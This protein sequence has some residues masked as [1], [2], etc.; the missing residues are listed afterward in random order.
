MAEP[1]GDNAALDSRLRDAFNQAAEQ[2]DS[3]GVADAIRSRIAAGDSGASVAASTAPGWGGGGAL[4]WLPWLG[5]IV[6]A[7]LGG[8]ALGASG[9]VGTEQQ[10]VEAGYTVVLDDTAPAY[11]CPGGARAGELAAGDRVLAIARSEDSGWL[12]VRDPNGFERVLWFERS[13]VIV[14]TDQPDVATL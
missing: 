8:A 7:G 11:A 2:G 5:L 12:G 9:A 4:G 1:I 6:V 10:T 13:V 14:D 3:T